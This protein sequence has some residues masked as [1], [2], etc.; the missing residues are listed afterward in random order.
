[1]NEHQ[2]IHKSGQPAGKNKHKDG[3]K[4]GELEVAA[5]QA[6]QLLAINGGHRG[7]CKQRTT[8]PQRGPPQIAGILVGSVVGGGG[9]IGAGYCVMKETG[10][11]GR[12]KKRL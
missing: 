3:G 11:S 5:F 1:M 10:G 6:V 7:T 4:N 12:R 9:A 8:Y 2:G